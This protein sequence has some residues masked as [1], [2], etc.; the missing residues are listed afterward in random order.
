[1]TFLK[2][3]QLLPAV[4]GVAA[5]LTAIGTSVFGDI[6]NGSVPPATTAA[7]T[8]NGSRL[9]EELAVTKFSKLPTLSYQLRDGE[10]L[11]AWQIKPEV[12]PA[13]ARPR[14]VIVMVDTSASQAGR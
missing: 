12:A 14:D 13:A 6:R 2:R 3:L 1:M 8:D 4:L 11:F 7:R 9:T 10:V 5:I